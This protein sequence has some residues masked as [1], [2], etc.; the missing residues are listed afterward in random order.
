MMPKERI[1]R[2]SSREYVLT[3]PPP[4]NIPSKQTFHNAYLQPPQPNI[5][6]EKELHLPVR[7]PRWY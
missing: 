2:I 4:T 1:R 5:A 6:N 3:Q 7:T